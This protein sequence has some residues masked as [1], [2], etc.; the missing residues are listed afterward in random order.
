MKAN[1]ALTYGIAPNTVDISY[2]FYYGDVNVSV[3]DS[4]TGALSVA[5]LIH[6]YMGGQDLIVYKASCTAPT[7]P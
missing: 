6:G 2:D 5:C 4:F 7:T 3:S 1:L